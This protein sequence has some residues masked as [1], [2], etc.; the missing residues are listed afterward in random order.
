MDVIV[1]QKR[2]FRRNDHGVRT[3][4]RT[5][6]DQNSLAGR[7]LGE[8]LLLPCNML[9]SGEDVFLDDISVKELSEEH[10]NTEIVIVDEGGADLVSAVLDPIEHKKQ[11]R[12]QMYEQTGSSNCGQ[13]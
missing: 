3:D 9:R 8:K 6:S 4:H 5:G 10:W 7:D 13:A 1:H 11:I 12:R 2:L